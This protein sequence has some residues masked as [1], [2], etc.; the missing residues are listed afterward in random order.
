[1]HRPLIF[2]DRSFR[3][4]LYLEWILLG[5]TLLGEIRPA[6]YEIDVTTRLLSILT[7]TVFGLMGLKLPTGK[8]IN[9]V[10][11]TG[12]E[13]G[14]LFLPFPL[15]SRPSLFPLLC[16]LIV[17]RSCLLFGQIGRLTVAGLVFV[18]FLL[19]QFLVWRP[20][21]PP[22]SQPISESI[23]STILTLKLNTAVTFGLTL[24]FILL[25]VNALLA[26]RQSREK[27]LL[28]NNQLREYALRI[29]DQ[30]MLQERNRIAREIHDSLGH[31]L[32]AQSIQL[33]NA[34]LFLPPD[35]EK[36]GSFL[37][38]AKQLGSKALQEVR[39][40]ISTLRSNPLQGQS[41]EVAIAKTVSEFQNTTGILPDC[42]LEVYGALP[43]EITT[44]LYRIVQESL[45][46]IYKHSGATQVKLKLQQ[47]EEAIHL[48][49]VDNGQGF[50]PNQNTTG[51]GLQ[52]MRERTAAL[53][54][55]FSLTSQPQKGC[56]IAVSIGLPRLAL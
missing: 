20:P 38:E 44:A 18:A 53:G 3:L 14:L 55:Q 51:F 36:T 23:T 13:F 5:I 31:A 43:A 11:Y 17:I 39:R 8:I 28:A 49:I 35:A 6:P 41:L 45:T 29:E 47:I 21:P 12:L 24:L 27:L 34:L 9:K 32:T 16:L 54:G 52:G 30:A 37:R 10:L 19:M 40:S 25:L 22:S 33:E 50:D 2:P 48:E 7:L 15:N 56:R 4:L 42:N 26:E 46:N 1:M